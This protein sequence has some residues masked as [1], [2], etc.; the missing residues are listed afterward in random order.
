MRKLFIISTL[1]FWL[2][3]AGFWLAHH[4]YPQ[5][6][7]VSPSPAIRTYS[8]ADVARHH[9]ADDCWLAIE[10]KIYDITSYLPDHPS[11]PDILT[12]W[13]GKESTLAWQNKTRG[14]SHSPYAQQLLGNYQIGEVREPR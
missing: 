3:V 11:A 7:P 1:L 14:R 9:Q 8:L 4:L 6:L 12:V 10:G 2:A 5:N 13:C